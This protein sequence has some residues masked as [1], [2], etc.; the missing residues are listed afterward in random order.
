MKQI[1][2]EVL[3]T[4]AMRIRIYDRFYNGE[5][6]GSCYSK[7][8]SNRAISTSRIHNCYKILFMEWRGLC[9]LHFGVHIIK[10]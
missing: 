2:N 4:Y 8:S 6:A 3:D 7:A 9:H 1:W 10:F 5:L